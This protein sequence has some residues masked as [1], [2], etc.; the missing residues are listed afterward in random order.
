MSVVAST[1]CG[2]YGSKHCSEFPG[3]LVHVSVSWLSIDLGYV[4][5]HEAVFDVLL[6]PYGG[7]NAFL[8]R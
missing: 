4:E 8:L 6:D 5:F 3:D 1:I 7:S 2:R